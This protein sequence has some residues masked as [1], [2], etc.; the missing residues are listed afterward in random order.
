MPNTI[1]DNGLDRS[2][3]NFAPLTPLTFVERTA[4]V[5]PDLPA[6]VYGSG[7]RAIRR[8]WR[9]LYARSRQLAH[10][11]VNA[12]IG[13]GDTVAVMLPNTPEMV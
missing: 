1:Y 3:A 11:L 4:T 10:A 13:R 8:N 6:I 12:G 2:A 5:F 9:D 7:L